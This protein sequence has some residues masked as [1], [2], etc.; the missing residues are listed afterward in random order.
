M[1]SYYSFR[2]VQLLSNTFGYGIMSV[3]AVFHSSYSNRKRHGTIISIVRYFGVTVCN[4]FS[5]VLKMYNYKI[6]V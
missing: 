1:I 5:R 4:T 6:D 2:F 3:N